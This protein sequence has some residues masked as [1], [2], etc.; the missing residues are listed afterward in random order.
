[1]P[2][3][4]DEPGTP[5]IAYRLDQFEKRA[6]AADARMQRIEALLTEIRFDLARKPSISGLWVMVATTIGAA[7]IMVSVFVSVLTY[8]QTFHPPH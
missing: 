7:S 5:L 6:D 8:L 2:P 1:M 3:D 4:P